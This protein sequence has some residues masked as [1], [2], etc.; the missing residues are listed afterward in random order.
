[1]T[2]CSVTYLRVSRQAHDRH[3]AGFQCVP[4]TNDMPLD[5][6]GGMAVLANVCLS[7]GSAV[8]GVW[9]PVP[10]TWGRGE[11]LTP[12]HPPPPLQAITASPQGLL[13]NRGW[14]EGLRTPP[15][16]S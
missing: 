14:W 5:P 7:V 8:A 2:L 13:E 4:V 11:L 15:G 6:R 10:I 12:R 9:D 16:S 1:M 3:E